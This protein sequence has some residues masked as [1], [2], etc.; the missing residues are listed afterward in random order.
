VAHLR[1][2]RLEVLSGRLR[3]RLMEMGSSVDGP[4]LEPYRA[5]IEALAADFEPADVAVAAVA[6]LDADAAG[7]DATT[8][9]AEAVLPQERPRGLMRATGTP[10]RPARPGMTGGRAAPARSAHPGAAHP[11]P[12]GTPVSGPWVRVFVGGGRRMGMRPGDLVGAITA[13]ARVPGSAIG[14]IQITDSFS[15]VDVSGDVVDRVIHALRD[16]TIRGRNL[17]VRLDR[18]MR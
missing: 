12:G 11:P 5:I 10:G 16:A 17:P 7:D 6:M 15:L 4:G 1:E 3:E 9:I 8:E 13:E 2:R 18:D 14:A